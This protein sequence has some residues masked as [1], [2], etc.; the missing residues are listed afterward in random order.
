[1]SA[2][3]GLDVLEGRTPRPASPDS[4]QR[5][6]ARRANTPTRWTLPR[7]Q[8][9]QAQLGRFADGYESVGLTE[10]AA[11]IRAAIDTAAALAPGGPTVD[12]EALRRDLVA[13][14]AAG[15]VTD[16]KAAEQLHAVSADVTTIRRGLNRDARSLIL[17]AAIA[18]LYAEGDGLAVELDQVVT[19]AAG[20]AAE[21]AGNLDGIA[22]DN[23]AIRIGGAPMGA[24]STI[25]EGRQRIDAAWRLAD[26]LRRSGFTMTFPG[27]QPVPAEVWRWRNLDA[28]R[29]VGPL[30]RHGHPNLWLLAHI[31][32]GAGPGV[33]TAADVLALHL[34]T[35]KAPPLVEEPAP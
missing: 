26:A 18:D 10:R 25:T 28:V 2:D 19:A 31:E 35:R 6:G 32:A 29:K 16:A 17:G 24:W 14:V 11:N 33:L 9:N 27:A 30:E 4:A 5:R 8:M 7:V 21:A 1:M 20:S 15:K 22:D 34:D 13:K 3:P 23:D 12:V